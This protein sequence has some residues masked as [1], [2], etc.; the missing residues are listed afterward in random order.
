MLDFIEQTSNKDIKR[1]DIA[2]LFTAFIDYFFVPKR[3]SF[4][5]TV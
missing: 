1:E 5:Q 4:H 2:N 3:D